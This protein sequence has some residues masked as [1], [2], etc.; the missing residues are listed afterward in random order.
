MLDVSQL[1][2]INRVNSNADPARASSQTD[3]AQKTLSGNLDQFLRLLTT[4]LK[5]QDPTSPTDTNALTQQIASLSQVEQQINTNKNLESL[6]SAFAA[7]QYNSV[8][9][10]IGKQIEA[11]GNVSALKDGNAKFVFYL[12]K[13][14]Q[15][16][17][18]TIKDGNGVTVYTGTAGLDSG[19]NEFVWN[20]KNNLGAT[21]PNGI[22]NIT[23]NTKDSA[24]GTINTVPYISGRVTS[25]DSSG[26]NVY[27]SIGEISVLLT[28]I[29]SISEPPAAPA[30]NG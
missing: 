2:N 15:T 10:Y 5:N 18:I 16:N 6:I 3:T 12:P 26:G 17:Q 20:G 11:P 14:A 27:A 4:Q 8:V 22:Y 25:I 13:D 1:D 19:R 9:N 21:Q 7:T 30:H 23:Y 28:K 29:T 24:G